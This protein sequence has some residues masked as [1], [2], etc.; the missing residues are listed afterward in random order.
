MDKGMYAA[1][2]GL[3]AMDEGEVGVETP[4]LQ[5]EIENP[6]S[7]T[8]DDGSVEITLEPGADGLG[9][10]FDANLAEDMDE[11]TLSTIANDIEEMIVADI[12]SRK[13]WADSYVKG[14]EVL[15]MR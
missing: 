4:D 5:I 13:D 10:E 1:P 11:G 7:V 3:A 6:D 8:L 14:L 2:Q 15:G 9:G 12:N